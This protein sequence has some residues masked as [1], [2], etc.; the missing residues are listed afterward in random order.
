M[1]SAIMMYI[2]ML[3][4]AAVVSVDAVAAVVSAEAA[5]LAE[6]VVGVVSEVVGVGTV[7]DVDAAEVRTRSLDDLLLKLTGIRNIRYLNVVFR[8]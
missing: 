8:T 3:Q 1:N 4:V 2:S 6:A 7:V 5:V